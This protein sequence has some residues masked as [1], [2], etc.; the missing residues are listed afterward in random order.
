MELHQ[1]REFSFKHDIIWSYFYSSFY[2]RIKPTVNFIGI[3]AH[4]LKKVTDITDFD[5]NIITATVW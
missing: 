4:S 5:D 3:G 2:Y 1:S